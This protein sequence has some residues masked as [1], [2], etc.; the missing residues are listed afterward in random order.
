MTSMLQKIHSLFISSVALILLPFY[1]FWVGIPKKKEKGIPLRNLPTLALEEVIKSMSLPERIRLS[2][3]SKRMERTLCRLSR[4]QPS[5]SFHL[6]VKNE[7]FVLLVFENAKST[8]LIVKDETMENQDV[9]RDIQVKASELVSWSNPNRSHIQDYINFSKKVLNIIPC[10]S[11]ELVVITDN[12]S[13]Q[14]TRELLAE[15]DLKIFETLRFYGKRIVG[16]TLKMFMDWCDTSNSFI[17]VG[18]KM[19]W[20]YRH[21]KAF[22]FSTIGYGDAGWVK[23]ENL[24]SMRN[25]ENVL[26]E[27][28]RFSPKEYNRLVKYWINCEHEMFRTL[29]SDLNR[30]QMSVVLKDIV[31]VVNASLGYTFFVVASSAQRQPKLLIIQPY[32]TFLYFSTLSPEEA[33]VLGSGAVKSFAREYEVLNVLCKM[34]SLKDNLKL[35]GEEGTT[36]DTEEMNAKKTRVSAEIAELK[37]GLI[38]NN[39][40]FRNGKVR[41]L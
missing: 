33:M 37:D 4:K 9:E 26:L 28:N 13:S 18:P 16:S 12:L 17:F 23:I 6:A 35:I 36:A 39:V 34:K 32:D 2:L 19:P 27:G 20:N 21:N 11:L 29:R 25:C 8:L 7:Q 40:A 15:P 14:F 10:N 41:V 3:T 30:I 38:A 22:K 5:L 1:I 31:Y 24:F